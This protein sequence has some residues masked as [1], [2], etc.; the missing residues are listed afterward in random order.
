MRVS[1]FGCGGTLTTYCFIYFFEIKTI[2]PFI[3][4]TADIE[5]LNKLFT[6]SF[7]E[8]LKIRAKLIVLLAGAR[9]KGGELGSISP[10]I[11]ERYN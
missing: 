3:L 4:R 2:A 10:G 5:C 9:T 8:L 6:T 11:T 1:A 7:K